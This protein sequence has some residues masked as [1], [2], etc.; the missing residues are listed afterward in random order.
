MCYKIYMYNTFASSAK[1]CVPNVK[2]DYV[3]RVGSLDTDGE[4]VRRVEGEGD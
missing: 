3:F 2:V 1:D 4:R